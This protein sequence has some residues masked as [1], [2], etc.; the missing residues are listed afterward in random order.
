MLNLDSQL[1]L[2]SDFLNRPEFKW[3][4]I[5]VDNRFFPIIT[6]FYYD[7]KLWKLSS[8]DVY[9]P[10]NIWFELWKFFPQKGSKLSIIYEK[11]IKLWIEIDIDILEIVEYN[12]YKKNNIT[13]NNL[14]VS[15]SKKIEYVRYT[16]ETNFDIKNFNNFINKYL[17]AIKPDEKNIIKN[18]VMY[19]NNYKLYINFYEKNKN[20]NFKYKYELYNY[21]LNIR[22]IEFKNRIKFYQTLYNSWYRTLD[23]VFSFKNININ[24]I[25]YHKNI[26]VKK[27]EYVGKVH[28]VYNVVSSKQI[29]DNYIMVAEN[30]NPEFLDSF[31]RAKCIA[32]ETDSELSHAAIT[33]RELSIPLALW[34]KNI[35]IATSND[36]EI[37]ID[38]KNKIINL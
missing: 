13:F 34:S 21:F 29:K 17:K 22:L 36:I 37:N 3:K 8:L 33:C 23:E 35:F 32:V 2:I 15:L 28:K 24:K 14:T 10:E 9:L 11:I 12:K 7:L 38:T 5:V 4:A 16:K 1:K 20:K 19:K 6:W 25:I 31:Y 18:I 27:D 30:T 26:S